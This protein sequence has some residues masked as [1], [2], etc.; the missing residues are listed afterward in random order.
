MQPSE[1]RDP[2]AILGLT[3]SASE[4]EIRS[5]YRA[6]ARKYH[7]DLNPAPGAMALMKDINW[8]YG[9]LGDPD[10]R[11]AYDAR[12]LDADY[13]QRPAGGWTEPRRGASTAG[14]YSVPRG[15]RVP[16]AAIFLLIYLL[17]SVLRSCSAMFQEHPAASAQLVQ[18]SE[19][20]RNPMV[21]IRDLVDNNSVYFQAIR[22]AYP[23]YGLTN[24]AGLS[25]EVV[26]A[27]LLAGQNLT[28]ETRHYGTLHI[29]LEQTA[30]P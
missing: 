6:L 15:R 30:A 29:P 2:Y 20:T 8:A 23:D 9:L 18:R 12:P 3:R 5:A 13:S 28:L 22:R 11:A 7:P 4:D 25:S 24:S 10:K 26:H 17:S 16:A 1:V 14:P 19:P 21:D 27:Y